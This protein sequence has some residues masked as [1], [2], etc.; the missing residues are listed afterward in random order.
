MCRLHAGSIQH[1]GG[2]WKECRTT[3]L[4]GCCTVKPVPGCVGSTSSAGF[5]EGVRIGFHQASHV[6]GWQARSSMQPPT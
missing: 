5:S 3:F 1:L 6:S 4:D 2:P